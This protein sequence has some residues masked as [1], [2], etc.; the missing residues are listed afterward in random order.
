[1]SDVL[2]YSHN[3]EISIRKLREYSL[4]PAHD[5]GKHKARVFKSALGVGQSEALWLRAEILRTL[6]HAG[7]VRQIED[8]W[9][10]RYA[11]D[12]EI[13]RGAKSAKVRTTWIIVRGD[14]RPQLTSCWV[15]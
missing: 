13:T 15:I 3:A 4:N 12:I 2:P 9:G 14:T 10:V 11:V 6:P 5:D 8:K 1:M 7:A